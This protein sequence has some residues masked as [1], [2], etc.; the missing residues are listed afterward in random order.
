MRILLVDGTNLTRIMNNYKVRPFAE[1]DAASAVLISQIDK[2]NATYA[3]KKEIFFDGRKR[4]I[5]KDSYTTDIFYGKG[6]K[7]D[8]LI[9][10]TVA[11]YFLNY[12]PEEIIVVTSDRDLG[13][14]CEFYGAQVVKSEN[15]L[16]IWLDMPIV[17]C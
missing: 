8:E 4:K 5:A 17:S 15:F 7:A 12:K 16:T 14:R 3:W 1:E 6:K 9:V 10:N 2:A 11:E 13:R